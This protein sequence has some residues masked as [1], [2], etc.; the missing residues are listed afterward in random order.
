MQLVRVGYNFVTGDDAVN[1]ED[2]ARTFQYS[3]NEIVI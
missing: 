2:T 3:F 1:L